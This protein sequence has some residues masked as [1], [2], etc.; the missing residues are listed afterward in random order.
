[1][2]I[3]KEI[4]QH[5]QNK[6]TNQAEESQSFLLIYFQHQM[7]G[8]RGVSLIPTSPADLGTPRGYPTIQFNLKSGQTLHIKFS[9][10]KL[11]SHFRCQS[12]NLGLLYL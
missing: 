12:Q 11:A 6:S 4:Y 8:K 9:T 10:H 3:N 1:M 7:L 5:K 2:S